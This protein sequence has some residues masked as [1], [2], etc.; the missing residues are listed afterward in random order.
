MEKTGTNFQVTSLGPIVTRTATTDDGRR[1]ELRDTLQLT[2]AE[3]SIN[4][5]GPN[6]FT[7]FVHA[8]KLNEE[9]YFILKGEG[10]FKVDDDEFAVN[11]GDMIRVNP[12]GARAIKAG[13]DGMTYMCIQVEA[14][15][16]HQATADD[17]ILIEDNAA[18]WM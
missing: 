14:N 13:N 11:E 6:E 12:A 3:I 1:I 2:G 7:P 18:S 5:Y 9:I 8:H 10:V 16:L 15:S 4:S 17:G